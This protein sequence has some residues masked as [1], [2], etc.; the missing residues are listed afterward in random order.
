[1]DKSKIYGKWYFWEELGAL[2]LLIYYR[3]RGKKI[4]QLLFERVSK[5]KKHSLD[6]ILSEKEKQELLVQYEELD[7]FFSYYF[8]KIDKSTSHNFNEKVKYCLNQYKKET[9][10]IISASKL[11]ILQ[12]NF[13]NG[14]ENTLTIYF[15]LKAK[16]ERRL[17]LSDILIGE[18]TVIRLKKFLIDKKF[19]DENNNLIVDNKSSF[20]RLHRELKEIN[21]INK[22]F[23]DNTI[24]DVMQKEYNSKF[25]KGLFSKAIKIKPDELEEEIIEELIEIL[26]K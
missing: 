14:A 1:M 13:L 21:F 3:L 17:Y 20:I 26:T 25:D 4:K 8:K 19:I 18:D 7:N 15:K 9:L 16:T 11:F 6:T 23:N 10:S 5:A 22:D 2:P 12:E 24:I